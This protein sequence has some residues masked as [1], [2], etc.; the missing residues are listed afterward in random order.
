MDKVELSPFIINSVPKSGLNLLLQIVKGIPN[1]T[2]DITPLNELS[3]YLPEKFNKQLLVIF[4]NKLKSLRMNEFL[5]GHAVY[6]S[7]YMEILKKLN[8]KSIYLYRDP[9]D[10]LISKVYYIE[11][12]YFKNYPLAEKLRDTSRYHSRKQRLLTILTSEKYNFLHFYDPFYKWLNKKTD[13]FLPI[14]FENLIAET[15]K[16][17][18]Y[19]SIIDF[20][21]KN[22][23]ENCDKLSLVNAMKANTNPLKSHTFRKGKIGSWKEEFDDE[24]KSCFK[25][26]AGN[27]LTRYGFE[28]DNNW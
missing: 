12:G 17:N 11:K 24:I 7:E 14:S 1:L 10:V 22:D 27:L 15:T 9:R 6:N 5:F 13:N 25:E 4:D 19:L 26:Y 16:N 21:L 20:I 18:I 3:C 8:I 2:C 23:I 28:Q